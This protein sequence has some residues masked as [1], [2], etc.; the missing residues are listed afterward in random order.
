[1]VEAAA[2]AAAAAAAVVVGI[3]VV[4]V[5]VVAAGVGVAVEFETASI[6]EDETVA[7]CLDQ[8]V[9]C[10]LVQSVSSWADCCGTASSCKGKSVE[11]GPSALEE[12]VR[13]VL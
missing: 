4:V 1:V 2:A 10:S 3:A 9:E 8:V 12:V 7:S 6:I 13:K 5:V 11:P